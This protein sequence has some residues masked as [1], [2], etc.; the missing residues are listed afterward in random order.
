MKLGA[1]A[2]GNAIIVGKEILISCGTEPLWGVLTATLAQALAQAHWLKHAT[3][4]P[5]ALIAEA[6]TSQTDG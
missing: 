3:C 6:A 5:V 2:C 1:F 4:L